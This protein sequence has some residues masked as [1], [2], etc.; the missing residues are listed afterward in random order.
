MKLVGKINAEAQQGRLCEIIRKSEREESGR[1]GMATGREAVVEH[2]RAG[3]DMR[4]RII[5]DAQTQRKD[6][7]KTQDGEDSKASSCY[8]TTLLRQEG[9]KSAYIECRDGS[10]DRKPTIIMDAVGNGFV[11]S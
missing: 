4:R 2:R 9:H 1:N 10:E 8:S 7:A 6:E 3:H 11:E 5:D